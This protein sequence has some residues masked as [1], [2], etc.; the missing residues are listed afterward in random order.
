MYYNVLGRIGDSL[1]DLGGVVLLYQSACGADYGTL[2]AAHAA[3]VAE[4]LVEGAADSCVKASVYS[5]DNAY[6]LLFTC[7][8]AATAEYALPVSRSAIAIETSF[9]IVFSFFVFWFFFQTRG[10]YHK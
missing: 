8:Y 4:I 9:F 3:Y 2:T 5:A 10:L 1:E 7:G 6:I